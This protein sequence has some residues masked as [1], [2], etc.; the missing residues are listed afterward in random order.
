MADDQYP[1]GSLIEVKM[2]VRLPVGATEEQITEWVEAE[3]GQCGGVAR[4]NPLSSHG[5]EAWGPF[6]VEWEDTGETGREEQFDH[7]VL[8][9]DHTSYRVRYLRERRA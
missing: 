7:K 8:G 3:V 2:T 9:P 4:D 6:G 1:E 5:P